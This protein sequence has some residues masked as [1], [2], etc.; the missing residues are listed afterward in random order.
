M[1]KRLALP[2]CGVLLASPT[3]GAA[4]DLSEYILD[5]I[6]VTASRYEKKD[7]DIPASTQVF[8]Q[9]DIQAM[10]A[11]SVME[12]LANIPGFSIS[13]SPSGN[14]SPGIRGIT[15]HLSILINGI[16]LSTESYYQMGT[17][18]M[19]GIER[20]EV[21]KGG[22][23]VLYGSRASVGVVNIITKKGGASSLAVGV[24]NHS[25]KAVSGNFSSEGLSLSL[26][27]YHTKDAGLV[28]DSSTQYYRKFLKRR[29]LMMQYEPNEHWNFMYLY[30]DKANLCTRF[31]KATGREDSPWR[32]DTRYTMLQ[33][34][35]KADDL[36]LTAYYQDRTWD[37]HLGPRHNT[38]KGKH[39]GIDVV[40]QWRFKGTSLTVGGTYEAIRAAQLSPGRGWNDRNRNHGSLY[41]MTETP[42]AERTTVL[43][44]AREVFTGD[45]GNAFCPQ[46]QV[47]QKLSDK[48]SVYLNVNKSLLEP[49]LSQ[50]YGYMSTTTTPNPD[51]KPEIGWMYEVG[52]KRSVNDHGLV[53]VGLYHM[54]IDDR[55]ST[56]RL[57]DG[58]SQYYNVASYK[59]TGVEVSYEWA[60]PK[61]L[62]YSVGFSYGDPQAQT[63]STSPWAR[64][65]QRLGAHGEVRYTMG[66]TSV[67]LFANYA[68]QRYNS[69]VTGSLL[70]VDMNVRYQ[71][72]AQDELSLKVSNLL[73][74]S[75]FRATGSAVLP[76]RNILLTYERSF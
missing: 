25:Q 52:W 5:P 15:G 61:G 63:S 58:T 34:T 64:T 72:T 3:V 75:D 1:M 56:R 42:V 68:S 62:S 32:N 50:R 7:L 9:E 13:E 48:E 67:N 70:S 69:D 14:G 57:A 54:K 8:T 16:P 6:Y 27:W 73:N 59:N 53:K 11:K 37:S 29:S 33:G 49:A 12:V 28:Y 22:S 41:F 10:N 23:A 40:N 35:Y 38:D 18:S 43:V 60:V 66:K 19:G 21:V 31:V 76:E 65:D 44:G 30:N 74:R 51:L 26:D 36:R 20:I 47:L 71:M 4:E 55:I 24:G 39:Y 45:S 46:V 17:L 2:L